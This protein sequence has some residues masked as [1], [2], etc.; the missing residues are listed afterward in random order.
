M[1]ISVRSCEEEGMLER[2]RIIQQNSCSILDGGHSL[3]E[4]QF[5]YILNR[6]S[7]CHQVMEN[8]QLALLKSKII[9]FDIRR[10]VKFK[11]EIS[12]IIEC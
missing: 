2:A 5:C 1:F 8:R 10:K 6:T 12:N 9:H 4:R 11:N 3:R 7:E